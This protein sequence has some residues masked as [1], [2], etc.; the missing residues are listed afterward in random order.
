MTL[1]NEHHEK[2]GGNPV[3]VVSNQAWNPLQN[4]PTFQ[5]SGGW[6]PSSTTTCSC[7]MGEVMA[8]AESRG[9]TLLYFHCERVTTACY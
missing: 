2:L 9:V 6:N 7:T 5:E 4:D 8:C 3:D 1:F